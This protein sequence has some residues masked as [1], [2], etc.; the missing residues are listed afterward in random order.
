[1]NSQKGLSS[2]TLRVFFGILA[3]LAL[4]GC[5]ETNV[6]PDFGYKFLDLRPSEWNGIWKASSGDGAVRFEVSDAKNG[7]ITITEAPDPK[8]KKAASDTL[9]TLRL[10]G[11]KIDDGLYFATILDKSDTTQALTP[12]LVHRLGND[13]SFVFWTINNEAV[14][15]AIKAGKL[16]GKVKPEKGGA[17][18]RIDSDPA[19][20]RVLVQPG[21]WNWM[22][23]TIVQRQCRKK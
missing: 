21:F 10:A 7:Q 17:H 15:K 12:Y 5:P 13:S 22:D 14:A 2:A 8:G 3:V 20:Y 16:K 1:M 23:P 18:S 4:A 9:M 11:T 6:G 19:N